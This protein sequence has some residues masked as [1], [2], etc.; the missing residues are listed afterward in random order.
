GGI[1]DRAGSSL[2]LLE[3]EMVTSPAEFLA[4]VH[5]VASAQSTKSVSWVSLDPALITALPA[6]ES[7]QD[8][9]DTML[10]CHGDIARSIL[11]LGAQRASAKSFTDPLL[12]DAN[13]VR[14][15]DAEIFWK[16]PRS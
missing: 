2:S 1:Y 9:G 12:L 13:Y 8:A 14:R 16:D 15:S 11:E 3:K 5:T 7:R 10:R 6:W 4:L